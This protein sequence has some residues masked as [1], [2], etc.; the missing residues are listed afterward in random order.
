MKIVLVDDDPEMIDVMSIALE[1][2]GHAVTTAHGG[3]SILSTLRSNRPDLLITDLMMAEMDGIQLCEVAAADDKLA[4]MKVIVISARTDPLWKDRAK[5]CGAV[6]FIEKPF[7]PATFA[8][9]VEKLTH[10]G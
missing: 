4:A 10:A 7:D 5:A 1:Q 3:V 6:G 2:A 8:S 9:T